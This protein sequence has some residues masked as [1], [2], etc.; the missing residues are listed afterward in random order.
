[1]ATIGGPE[2]S[3]WCIVVFILRGNQSRLLAVVSCLG[4]YIYIL[5]FGRMYVVDSIGVVEMRCNIS[6]EHKCSYC[7]LYMHMGNILKTFLSCITGVEYVLL[8]YDN[9]ICL[10]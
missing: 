4:V 6:R 8:F 5:Y 9:K 7:V 2:N 3:S 1:M 10:Y